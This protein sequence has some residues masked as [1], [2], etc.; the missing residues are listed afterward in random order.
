MSCDDD[1][2]ISSRKSISSTKS[3]LKHTYIHKYVW[4]QMVTQKSDRKYSTQWS[5]I[6][7]M[8]F[9]VKQKSTSKTVHMV[10]VYNLYYMCTHI[11]HK[12]VYMHVHTCTYTCIAQT[13]T[14]EL[15]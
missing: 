6:A 13:I 5:L 10:T 8:Q 14:V 3:F 11:M 9:I 12:P 4:L 2:R 15:Q 7:M 1:T